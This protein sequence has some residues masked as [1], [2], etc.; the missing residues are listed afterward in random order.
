VQCKRT[1]VFFLVGSDYRINRAAKTLV[2]FVD[3]MDEDAGKPPKLNE[4]EQFIHGCAQQPDGTLCFSSS[5]YIVRK[6]NTLAGIA[7]QFVVNVI[8]QHWKT[9]KIV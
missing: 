2:T 8:M 5:K 3:Y 9:W 6:T 4:M 1:L 7:R